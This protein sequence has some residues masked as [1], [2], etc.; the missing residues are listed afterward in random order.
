MKLI[1][2]Y[3][4]LSVLI[5]FNLAAFQKLPA[6]NF[7][8]TIA[9]ADHQFKSGNFTTAL[10]SYQRALFF[11]EGRE[12]LYL[13][14]QIAEI[15]YS[16][17]DYES[18]QKFFGLAYNQ[19]DNDSLKTEL[20]FSKAFCQI[21]N[22]NFQL[23][24]IDLFSVNDTSGIVQKRLNFYLAT[25]YFGLEEFSQAK[26]YFRLCVSVKDSAEL[27]ELFKRRS[28]FS[29]SPQ[30]ARI[31]S[32]ILPGLGQSYSGDIKSG[33]N[34]LFLTSGLI[35]LGI[36]IGIRYSPVD[37][38]FAILPWYQRYYTGG[39]GKAEEIAERKRQ[40]KRN[41]VYNKILKLIAE[42]STTY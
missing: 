23:A 8:E 13:F 36:N 32:M 19:T 5:V 27:T 6:Q 20:L 26:T 14:R 40:D 18:A 17:N 25:C 34:S 15:S 28:I 24:L 29:P 38:I 2:K 10:K 37:A 1:I 30:K 22:K 4:N 11:S 7:E 31:M 33:L 21:L 42:N 9:F 35:A 16:N 3:L 12:N 41:N 39:Y